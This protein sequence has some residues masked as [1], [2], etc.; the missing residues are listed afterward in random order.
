[1]SKFSHLVFV[2]LSVC[3]YGSFQLIPLPDYI[4]P[5]S[6][7]SDECFTKA[8]LDAIPGI[9]QGIPEAGI[10]PLD[11][12]YL[13]KNIS[14]TLPGNLK[15]TFHN[16]KLQG[17]SSCIPDKVSSRRK[18]RTF[19]FDMHCNFT[20]SGQ[21]SLLG[22]LLL[23]NLDTEGQA[24]IKIY[25]QRIR[26]EV[27]ERVLLNDQGEGHYKINSYKYKA[28][29]GTDLKLNLTNLIRGNPQI[30][31]NVLQVLNADSQALAKD[32]GGPILDYAIDYAMNVTQKFF[33][34]YTYDQISHV[35]LTEDFFEKE[36]KH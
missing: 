26:L 19:V 27:V 35:P 34:A 6:E 33:D 1:M 24:K 18:K 17:L 32:F 16:A 3:I 7:L 20:V 29:Y 5:C 31:A 22:R 8:T 14:M 9:V 21:Y 30:S 28:D 23:F 2:V 11:P 36:E 25:N 4:H 15:M 13:D 12:L 10:P